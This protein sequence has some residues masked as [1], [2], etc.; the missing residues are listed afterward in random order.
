QA[1]LLRVIQEGTYKRVGGNTWHQ[2]NFRLICATNRDLHQE[3]ARGH[4]RSD[5]YYRLSEWTCTLPSLRERSEDILPLVY[6]FIAKATPGGKKPELTHPVEAFFLRRAYPG[7]VRELKQVVARILHRYPGQGPFTVGMI[8][9]GERLERPDMAQEWCDKELEHSVRRA[10][11]SGVGLKAI[12]RKVE[13]LAVQLAVEQEEGNL[14][15]A[16]RRLGVTDR[17]LQLRRAM[18]LKSPP[19]PQRKVEA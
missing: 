11:S 4:F 7:N 5:L 17:A 14:Q 12:G 18:E 15:K 10:L 8:P 1:Q 3:V 19:F 2:T 13:S 9:E 16:A 6:H